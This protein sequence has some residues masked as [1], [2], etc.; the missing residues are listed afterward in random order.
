MDKIE[1]VNGLE[2]SEGLK[3]LWQQLANYFSN[4]TQEDIERDRQEEMCIRDRLVLIFV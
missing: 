3:D 4:R 1:N 2:R